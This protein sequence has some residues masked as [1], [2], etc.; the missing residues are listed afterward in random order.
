MVKISFHGGV[1]EIGGNKILLDDGETRIFLDFGMSFGIENDYFDQPFISP[2]NYMDLSLIGAIPDVAGIYKNAGIKAMYDDKGFVGVYGELEPRSVNAF[3][4]SHAHLDHIGYIGALRL[5]IPF[6]GSN[7]TKRFLELRRDISENWSNKYDLDQFKGMEDGETVRIGSAE[8]KHILVDHSIPGSSA[9]IISMGS[10]NIGY[11]G[12]LRLHGRRPELTENFMREA[13][14]AKLDYLLCEGTRITTTGKNEDLFEK[15]AES[16]SLLSESAVQSKMKT[17]LSEN[18][19]LIIYD[20]SPADL[21]R[22]E[23]IVQLARE[24]GR[25]VLLDTK[26]SYIAQGINCDFKYYPSLWQFDSCMLLLPRKKETELKPKDDDP[27]KPKRKSKDLERELEKESLRQVWEEYPNLFI[28]ARD[29]GRT[30][31]VKDI[32]SVFDALPE[33]LCMPRIVWGKQREEIERHKDELLI[34][35]SSGPLTMMH[36]GK[37]ISGTYVYGKAEPFSEE[38]EISFRK[39]TN[40]TKLFG[41]EIEYAHTSGHAN[42]DDLERIVKT[43]APKHLIPIHTTQADLFKTMHDSV[44][45]LDGNGEE[46]VFD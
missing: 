10:L 8:V 2:Q 4:F 25:K 12:D 5:D 17:I 29:S 35:T 9:F 11:T 30:A 40:W 19:G 38:M 21:D 14:N 32:M 18:K 24:S 13:K 33:N 37:G 46:C 22:M 43:I 16:H 20:A 36:I 3:L 27:S 44:I 7:I 31:F 15:E 23:M 1:N 6:Y 41:M 45:L 39:L 26:K 42:R 34:Y 28:E